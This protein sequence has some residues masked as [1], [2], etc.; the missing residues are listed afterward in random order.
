M[1]TT[2]KQRIKRSEP[3]VNSSIALSH[4]AALR[5]Q[6]RRFS[7]LEIAY[8]LEHGRLIRRT[9]ICFY[10]LA[11]K[12]VPLAD[13]RLPWIQ[14]LVGATLLLS[15]EGEAVITMYKNE[16]ALREIKRKVKFRLAR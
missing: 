2:N 12:D 15:S 1:A 14:R 16:N 3:E 5:C 13:R 6:Q 9:G 7:Q 8:V 4:H 11:A 10:F